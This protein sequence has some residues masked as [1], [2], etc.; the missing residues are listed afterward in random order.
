MV[1]SFIL[2]FFV[3][4]LHKSFCLFFLGLFKNDLEIELA[5]L[6]KN[7]NRRLTLSASVINDNH[8]LVVHDPTTLAPSFLIE[9]L[10]TL[11]RQV[12]RDAAKVTGRDVAELLSNTEGTLQ[13]RVDVTPAVSKCLQQLT[14]DFLFILCKYFSFSPEKKV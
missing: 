7:V 2:P 8:S 1:N 12:I 10:K 5:K 9:R 13:R 11:I 6:D 3:F 14:F 4:P